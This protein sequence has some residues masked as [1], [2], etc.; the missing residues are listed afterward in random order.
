MKKILAPILL[1]AFMAIAF[2]QATK[3]GYFDVIVPN[4]PASTFMD[5]GT[6]LSIN[7]STVKIAD[8]VDDDT[9][10]GD[11][12]TSLVTE[13]AIKAYVDTS[14]GA[15]TSADVVGPAGA[16]DNAIPLYDG[17][18]GKL[19]KNSTLTYIADVLSIAGI[20][21]TGNIGAVD[22]AASGDLTGNTITSTT[23]ISGNSVASTTSVTGATVVG[24]TSTSGGNLLLSGN[25]IASTDTNGDVNLAPDGTGEVTKTTTNGIFKLGVNPDRL[26]L[27]IHPSFETSVAEGSCSGCTASSEVTE[28]LETGE[29]KAS[30]EMA[31]SAATGCYTVTKTTSAQYSPTQMA[32]SCFIKTSAADVTFEA[33]VNG[34]SVL[35]KEVSSSDSWKEYTHA[36]VGGATSVGYR[37]C[38][39]TS[40]TD[41]VFVDECFLGAKDVLNKVGYDSDTESYSPTYTGFGTVADNVAF[42]K[43]SGAYLEI[44]A[45]ITMGTVDGTLASFTLPSGLVID[46]SKLTINS[47]SGQPSEKV[48]VYVNNG[49]G[50]IG[51]ILAST[52]T[53]TSILYFGN[54]AG[55]VSNMN[56][57]VV[58]STMGASAGSLTFSAKVPIVG[59]QA[60][61]DSIGDVGGGSN[62]RLD[63][64]NGYGSTG[65]AIRRFTN[66]RVNVGSGI[67]YTDSATD[68]A[69]FTAIR[70]GF[71]FASYSESANSSSGIAAISLN[72]SSLNVSPNS[73]ADSEVLASVQ[74]GNVTNAE[75]FS[76]SWAGWLW[77][78]DIIRPH[79]NTFTPTANGRT[80]FSIVGLLDQINAIL[81][82]VVMSPNSSTGKVD[83]F[84]FTFGTTDAVTDCTASPCSYL[85][86]IGDRVSSVTRS[87]TGAYTFNFNRTYLKLK[88]TQSST[89]GGDLGISSRIGCNNCA[90]TNTQYGDSAGSARDA[91]GEV[92]CHGEY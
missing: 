48:G 80:K 23:T 30:L 33:M 64:A 7:G 37:V 36:F 16:T 6:D 58:G 46:A 14:V 40:I 8:I 53:S 11:S 20:T 63:T 50:A 22:I 73:L 39:N 42:Y 69:S 44:Y 89:A 61:F 86:Q 19:I 57:P 76:V 75:N 55:N 4:N 45:S 74:L 24:T 65:T 28:I 31:Y 79:T 15:I 38:A 49:G 78:G 5:I 10:A 85:D 9:M 18:T 62:V 43:R 83:L 32:G 71:Y 35:S 92:L 12:A 51:A 60:T 59:W 54:K 82:D 2:A 56:F 70:S 77:A 26:N 52:N 3:T 90:S 72:A 34:V 13:Q 25:D 21:A 47:T 27:L 1:I 91:H 84:S 88:C 66:E 67:T 17:T 87:S 41:S 81:K 29:N 68:G